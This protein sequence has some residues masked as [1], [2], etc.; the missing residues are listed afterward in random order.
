M[1]CF[2]AGTCIDVFPVFTYP[3][4]SG[5]QVAL[6]LASES[7]KEDIEVSHTMYHTSSDS[8][9]GFIQDL[10]WEWGFVR[11]G[12]F[13]TLSGGR[14]H[15]MGKPQGFCMQPIY[16][17]I[18]LTYDCLLSQTCLSLLQ[19]KFNVMKEV[20]EDN[21]KKIMVGFS[22]SLICESHANKSIFPGRC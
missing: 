20:T 18:C 15:F 4:L 6:S 9:S 11:S 22:Q 3:V 21:I 10:N 7:R 14:K 13:G 19:S 12:A 1:C 8:Y 2:E 17:I 5:K 16:Y